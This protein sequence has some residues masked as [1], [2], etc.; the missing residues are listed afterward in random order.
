MIHITDP[1]DCCGCTACAAS[2]PVGAIRMV[3]TEGC[4]HPVPTVS[5]SQCIGCGACEFL[6]PSR[7]GS[8]ITV[9]G[10]SIHHIKG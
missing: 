1:K 8:A 3:E 5:E 4:V 10:N 9:R 7:P 2:C 6:C